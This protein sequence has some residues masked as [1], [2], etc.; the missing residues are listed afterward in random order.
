M[1]V[2]VES[3]KSQ[4]DKLVNEAYEDGWNDCKE[5][6]ILQLLNEEKYVQ[7]ENKFKLQ[8]SR[9][10]LAIKLL[11]YAQRTS[12]GADGQFDRFFEEVPEEETIDIQV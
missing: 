7:L 3:I 4:L 2:S 11:R 12:C 5:N 9:L 6:M 8:K 10:N 1:I